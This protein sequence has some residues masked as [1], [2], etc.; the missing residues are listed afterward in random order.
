MFF[1]LDLPVMDS[2]ACTVEDLE[3]VTAQKESQ[4]AVV[5][6]IKSVFSGLIN[7]TANASFSEVSKELYQAISSRFNESITDS[8]FT[9]FTEA[10]SEIS[11]GYAL[12]CSSPPEARPTA[13]DIPKLMKEFSTAYE[14]SKLL[15][16]RSI[17]G[18]MLCLSDLLSE[19]EE[20]AVGRKR[21][22]RVCPDRENCM[23][24]AGGI[25]E[26]IICTCEFFECLDEGDQLQPMFLDFDTISCLAFVIDTTGSMKDEINLAIDVIK[27]FLGSE[28]VGGCYL[29][30]PFNDNGTGPGPESCKHCSVLILIFN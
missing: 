10:I 16:I 12:A 15:E 22:Q 6:S 29:L 9:K 20:P 26:S 25:S 28:E 24:P 5:Q 27:D 13:E 23:C 8:G 11:S 4:D 21:R 30:V 1:Q 2:N 3:L 17:Y 7:E 18:Q 19:S 14:D